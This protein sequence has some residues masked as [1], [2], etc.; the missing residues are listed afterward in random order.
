MAAGLPPQLGG[1]CRGLLLDRLWRWRLGGDLLGRGPVDELDALADDV[2]AGA[3]LAL[4]LPLVELEAALDGDQAALGEV[5]DAGGACLPKVFTSQKT[6]PSAPRRGTARRSVEI[7]VPALVSTS[8]GVRV[9]R[10]VRLTVFIW[11]PFR[12]APEALGAV[13]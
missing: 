8:S 2:E 10:P 11:T 4:G 3:L 12:L 9:S 5:L 13:G 1:R 6:A 7:F